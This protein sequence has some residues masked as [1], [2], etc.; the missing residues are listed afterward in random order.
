LRI[1]IKKNK[2]KRATATKNSVFSTHR[3][4]T[5]VELVVVVMIFSLIM[6]GI[7]SF[8]SAGIRSSLK[9]Y[10]QL[11]SIRAAGEIIRQMQKDIFACQSIDTEGIG[12]LMNE[13]SKGEMPL[14]TL[15][16]KPL[17]KKITFSLRNATA[18][19]SFEQ[20]GGR[21]FLERKFEETGKQLVTQ[22][23]AILRMKN[24]EVLQIFKDQQIAAGNMVFRQGQLFVRIVVE[25]DDPKIPQGS[26]QLSTFFI[27][28]QFSQTNWWNYTNLSS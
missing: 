23:Y 9:G 17:P 25:S 11:E 27:T 4:F 22:R 24:F 26:V 3:G 19:Y 8:F 13:S 12:L 28:S 14:E 15:L 5:M 10:D 1:R 16:G 21:G 6:L 7:Q 20:K 2:L 18:S